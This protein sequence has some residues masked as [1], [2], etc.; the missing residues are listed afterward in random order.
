[1]DKMSNEQ[2]LAYVDALLDSSD[3]AM[4]KQALESAIPGVA[5][6]PA[7]TKKVD[8]TKNENPRTATEGQLAEGSFAKE[9]HQDV[10]DSS[11]GSQ[12]EGGVSNRDG[13]VASNVLTEG[14]FNA[15]T[16]D[17][18]TKI[19]QE[20]NMSKTQELGNRIMSKLQKNAGLN[21][22]AEEEM[23]EKLSAE[24]QHNV[25]MFKEAAD[26]HYQ[27]YITA[28][29][30]GFAKKAEQIEDI[31]ESTGASPEEAEAALD[32]IA[33]EDP[34]MIMPEEEG[35]ELG[36]DELAALDQLADELA[37]AGVTPEEL[38]SIKEEIAA[39]EGAGL[40]DKLAYEQNMSD[41]RSTV[42]D[43]LNQL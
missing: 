3:V 26:A 8:V 33:A 6:A 12:V 16:V 29:G 36:G 40:E 43:I 24:D 18:I 30:A 4:D 1:M 17:K 15:T 34:E 19:S 20:I 23:F 39:E 7:G 22:S 13:D 35:G 5:G 9:K 32:E 41:R 25:L 31:V 28:F 10:K 42:K 38:E 14:D 37:E 2:A 11:G 27:D 21:K